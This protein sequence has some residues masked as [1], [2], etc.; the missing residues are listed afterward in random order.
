MAEEAE[1]EINLE[2]AGTEDTLSE[3]E[4]EAVTHGWTPEGVEGKRNLSAEEF[5]DRQ[6]LYDDIRSLKKQTRKQQEAIEAMKQLQEGIRA[7]ER[8]KTINELKY[9]KKQALEEENYD[10]VIQI[11]DKIAEEQAADAA[12]ATNIAFEAWVDKNEW[13]HQD[14]EMKAYAD[15]IGAGYYQQNPTKQM[16]DVYTYVGEEIKKRFPDKFNNSNR[17]N[18]SS[19]EGASSGRK[20]RAT[21]QSHSARELPETDR[22]IMRTIVRSGAMTEANISGKTEYFE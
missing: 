21:A 12:P 9:Q 6:P 7:R 2:E 5:M 8:E 3:I 4:Q 1:V 20:G 19:V 10:A 13:Y 17:G 22:Q 15:M 18:P 11:D 14:H 16:E